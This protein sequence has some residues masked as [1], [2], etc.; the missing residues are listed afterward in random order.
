M[1]VE[2]IAPFTVTVFGVIL[3]LVAILDAGQKSIER[4]LKK[5]T[6]NGSIKHS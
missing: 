1:F 4:R 6:Q 3:A 2:F 5:E